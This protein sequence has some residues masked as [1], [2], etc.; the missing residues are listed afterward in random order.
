MDLALPDEGRLR[1]GVGMFGFGH[2]AHRTANQGIQRG[3]KQT[4]VDAIAECACDGKCTWTHMWID[5]HGEA[6]K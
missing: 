5:C 1:N 6:G 4:T 3:G 2:P